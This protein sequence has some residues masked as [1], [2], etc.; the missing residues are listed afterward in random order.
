MIYLDR[1][2]VGYDASVFYGFVSFH[3]RLFGSRHG[4]RGRTA[5]GDNR[6]S[7]YAQP[8]DNHATDAGDGVKAKR[9]VGNGKCNNEGNEGDVR[10]WPVEAARSVSVFVQGPVSQIMDVANTRRRCTP[11]IRPQ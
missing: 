3:A 10:D 8:A 9:N 4:N 5:D 11:Q 2:V 6:I 7:C 1:G